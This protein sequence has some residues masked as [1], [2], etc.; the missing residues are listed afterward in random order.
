MTPRDKEILNRLTNHLNKMRGINA[1]EIEQETSNMNTLEKQNKP[2]KSIPLGIYVNT[3]RDDN[4][5]I[6]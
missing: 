3:D 5:A 6:K 2:I 4:P 1:P